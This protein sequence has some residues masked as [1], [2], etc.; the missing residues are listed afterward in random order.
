MRGRLVLRKGRRRHGVCQSTILSSTIRRLSRQRV[1]RMDLTSQSATD[2][3]RYNVNDHRAAT[4]DC[5][6]QNARTSP[7][8]VHRIVIPRLRHRGSAF[9]VASDDRLNQVFTF[10]FNGDKY[11]ASFAFSQR[12]VTIITVSVSM[13]VLHAVMK[14]AISYSENSSPL[15]SVSRSFSSCASISGSSAG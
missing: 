7:L 10:H 9:I 14:P 8:R 4:S 1:I 15:K 12:S 13:H 2:V 11:Y 5:P 3:K 6:F